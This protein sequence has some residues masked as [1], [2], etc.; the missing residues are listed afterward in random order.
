MPWYARYVD[1]DFVSAQMTLFGLGYSL[2][3]APLSDRTA[4]LPRLIPDDVFRRA[5]DVARAGE[6]MFIQRASAEVAEAAAEREPLFDLSLDLLSNTEQ[7]ERLPFTPDLKEWDELRRS[8]DSGRSA[9]AAMARQLER[10]GLTAGKS[11]T[12]FAN[13]FA[14]ATAHRSPY[15]LAI[16]HGATVS[17]SARPY[18]MTVTGKTSHGV[19]AVVS[20]AAKPWTRSLRFAELTQ[21]HIPNEYGE[22]AMIGRFSESIQIDI[23]PASSDFAVELIYPATADASVTRASFRVTN[24]SS[25]GVSF[26]IDRGLTNI[27]VTG[28]TY[29]PVSGPSTVAPPPLA[30]SGAAQDMHL[31]GEG[32]TVSLLLNRPITVADASAVRDLIALTTDVAPIGYHARRR[33]TAARTSIPGAALH[34]DGRTMVKACRKKNLL[35]VEKERRPD[36]A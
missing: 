2:A 4:L 7:L 26:V 32:R 34:A 36:P 21:F 3:V 22:L 17:G 19:L 23:V 20:E 24:A 30:I 33:N 5:Q 12:D 1:P 9:A 35:R 27:I 10:V 18:A 28:G 6:R 25:N 29:V 14:A 11:A 13:D 8:E 16:V 15:A 31:N